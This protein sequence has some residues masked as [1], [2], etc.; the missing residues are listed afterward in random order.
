MK[1]TLEHGRWHCSLEPIEFTVSYIP[2]RGAEF[3]VL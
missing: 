3:G 1:I 2:K